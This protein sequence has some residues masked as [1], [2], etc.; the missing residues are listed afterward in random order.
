MTTIRTD[1]RT[2]ASGSG[3]ESI[4]SEVGKAASSDEIEQYRAP[5]LEGHESASKDYMVGGIVSSL[6]VV[7][8]I[9]GLVVRRRRMAHVHKYGNQTKA[10]RLRTA[11]ARDGFGLRHFMAGV[12]DSL[13]WHEA[14][15]QGWAPIPQPRAAST[16]AGCVH[17]ASAAAVPDYREF[18][19]F[20]SEPGAQIAYEYA[21]LPW[22]TQSSA[23]A[24]AT[25]AG[26][27]EY[28]EVVTEDEAD[29]SPADGLYVHANTHQKSEAYA[30]VEQAAV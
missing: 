23:G 4:D 30:F 14:E 24:A 18:N 8:I 21:E 26:A 27:H 10:E 17:V 11:A 12:I 28:L 5:V 3:T 22:P 1:D 9:G 16:T 20:E 2:S 25:T 6:V 15:G 29:L 13:P 7:L 19:D